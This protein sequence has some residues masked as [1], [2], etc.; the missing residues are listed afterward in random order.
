MFYYLFLVSISNFFK[1][2]SFYNSRGLFFIILLPLL[3]LVWFSTIPT[4]LVLKSTSVSYLSLNYYN[5]TNILSLT[6]LTDLQLWSELYYFYSTFEFILMNFYLY[7]AIL[8]VFI[9]FY[10]MNTVSMSPSV[11]TGLRDSFSD[12]QFF[13]YL[14]VQDFQKQKNQ[15]ASVR[16]WFKK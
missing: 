5:W 8:F 14:R 11:L 10:L 4:T 6:Y 9:L 15:K 2:F 13:N 1:N 7:L 3:S 16:V 12:L